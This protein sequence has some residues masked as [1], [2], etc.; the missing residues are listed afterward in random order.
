[1]KVAEVMSFR[2]A[3]EQLNTTQPNIS[4]RISSF[5]SIL[6]DKLFVRDV[7]SVRLTDFGE[8]LLPN[9]RRVLQSMEE[10]LVS[11]NKKPLLTGVLRLGVTE[12][13][14]HTWLSEFISAFSEHYPKV[15]VELT[16]DLSSNL[17]KSL[18]ERSLDIVLQ[19]GPFNR[20]S[21]GF[22][23]LG[24][25]SMVWVATSNVAQGNS[26]LSIND[27]CH[28][29]ILTHAKGTVPF[30]QLNEHLL[31]QSAPS[32]RVCSSTHLSACLQMT[33]DGLGIACLPN[34]MVQKDIEKGELVMLNYH[35]TPD[36]LE[37][38][39]RFDAEI[40]PQ[41]VRSAADIA[42]DVANAFS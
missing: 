24:Q 38:Y 7:S 36:P 29:T 5:E 15:D 26:A 17:S 42:A 31:N 27:L 6:E 9:A 34:A 18:F 25:L 1:M 33:K 39:A 35:W 21:S 40:C 3:A 37:F 22:V 23:E 8:T 11:A 41:Y 32:A 16:V 12:M 10:L 19:S 20:R 28:H 30:E 13:I 4:S 14:V 2:K